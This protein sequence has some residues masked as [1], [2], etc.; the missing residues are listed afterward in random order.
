MINVSLNDLAIVSELPA[1]RTAT[2]PADVSAFST[3]LDKAD[4]R[5][6]PP[7]QYDQRDSGEEPRAAKS[8]I[9]P[10]NVVE[11][12]SNDSP[13]NVE[14]VAKQADTDQPI[15]PD[16][17]GNPAVTDDKTSIS[18]TQAVNFTVAVAVIPTPINLAAAQ[19]NFGPTNVIAAIAPQTA[20]PNSPLRQGNNDIQLAA[21]AQT[22]AATPNILRDATQSNT[23]DQNSAAMAP[24]TTDS[25]MPSSSI[26][27][28]GKVMSETL[29]AVTTLSQA[30][31]SEHDTVLPPMSATTI[32][33]EAATQTDV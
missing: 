23:T 32:A 29:F 8:V 6:D 24:S 31:T 1:P 18:D 21:Q 19:L 27:A 13:S 4:A 20:S 26:P 14:T 33:Q 17:A 7:A 28:P 9:P 10:S 2:R 16:D 12:R 25:T 22:S 15:N 5:I 11:S 30:A 3:M